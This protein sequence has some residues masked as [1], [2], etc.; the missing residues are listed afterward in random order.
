[1]FYPTQGH[2]AD[3]G[4][5]KCKSYDQEMRWSPDRLR[6]LPH[7]QQRRV[8]ICSIPRR[9]CVFL[10]TDHGPLA[11]ILYE[12]PGIFAHLVQYGVSLYRHRSLA[13]ATGVRPRI[14]APAPSYQQGHFDE[15]QGIL[16]I[17]HIT[18][19]DNV[20]GSMVTRRILTFLYCTVIRNINY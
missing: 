15:F 16:Q 3:L 14:T 2:Q 6:R 13:F 19:K 5:N 4:T 11:F 9:T 10:P 7:S 8:P 17:P 12:R 1:M 20:V 18:L